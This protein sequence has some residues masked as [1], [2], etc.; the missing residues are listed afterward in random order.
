MQEERDRARREFEKQ[1]LVDQLSTERLRERQ[2]L[3]Q[4][5]QSQANVKSTIE[6]TVRGS[7][8][9]LLAHRSACAP[10]PVAFTRVL[11]ARRPCGRGTSR[12]A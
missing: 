11:C 1:R 10:A 12:S 6:N 3:E 4:T 9:S 2:M 5:K 8:L 7:L